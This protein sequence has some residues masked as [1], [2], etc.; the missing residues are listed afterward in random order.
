M[1]FS[2]KPKNPNLSSKTQKGDQKIW[3]I[4]EP[5]MCA[6]QSVKKKGAELWGWVSIYRSQR[7][8]KNRHGRLG[9]ESEHILLQKRSKRVCH[10]VTQRLLGQS[11]TKENSALLECRLALQKCQIGLWA[12]NTLSCSGAIWTPLLGFFNRSLYLDVFSS[13]VYDFSSLLWIFQAS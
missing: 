3:A 2:L 9:C 8:L 6:S 10:I 12:P 7:I 11:P 1:Q 13:P 5:K 4:W